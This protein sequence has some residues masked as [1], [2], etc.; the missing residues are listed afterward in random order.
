[1]SVSVEELAGL[2]SGRQPLL[3]IDLCGP[4][5]HEHGGSPCT[6]PGKITVGRE[7]NTET[8]ARFSN[9]CDPSERWPLAAKHL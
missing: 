2:Y 5:D 7:Y 3:L 8:L 6:Q 1:M 4:A 9:G